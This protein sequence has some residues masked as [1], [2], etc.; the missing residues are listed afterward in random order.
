MKELKDYLYYYEPGPPDIKIYC[1]DCLEIMPLLTSESMDMVWTDP[2]YGHNNHNEDLNSRLN[3][4]RGIENKPIENDDPENFK[5]VVDGAMT[6]AVR[7]LNK[8]CCCCCCGGGPKPT[9]AWVANRLDTNGLE[10]FHSV[11][12]DK[13][14]PGLGWRYRRQHEMIM[15]A[16]RV[17]GNL[18]WADDRTAVP[19]IVKEYPD[20]ERR[21]PNEKPLNM[22]KKFIFWHGGKNVLDPFLGSGTTLVACKEL[23]RNGI[24]IEINEKYCSIART[25]LLNTQVPFL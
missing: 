12:W 16:K 4:Y 13:V 20:R 15:V 11:I 8:D 19:N 18:L 3:E 9:F 5:H 22:V 7:I 10:F 23:K 14:N 24:G 1:G 17:G 2:P 21:H 6:E 25:R